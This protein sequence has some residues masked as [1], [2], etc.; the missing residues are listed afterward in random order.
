MGVRRIFSR[1]MPLAYFSRSSHENLF[2]GVQL[3]KLNF[4]FSTLRKRP[5][6]CK[7][8]AEK[9]QILKS[10]GVCPFLPPFRRHADITW[11]QRPWKELSANKFS[12]VVVSS[13][14]IS[15]L[16]GKRYWFLTSEISSFQD[17]SAGLARRSLPLILCSLFAAT[18]I[19]RN[20][21]TCVT[22]YGWVVLNLRGINPRKGN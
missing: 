12:P 22:R 5:F 1:G 11:F 2:R 7:S 8:V 9:C 4:S 20:L 10:R 17:E 16:S 13:K 21:W 3:V 14:Q 15:E 18:T 6:F 19:V